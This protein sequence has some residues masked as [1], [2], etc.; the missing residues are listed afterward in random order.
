[1]R[2]ITNAHSRITRFVA[3]VTLY[4]ALCTFFAVSKYR[5]PPS[6]V[7]CIP[8]VTTFSMVTNNSLGWWCREVASKDVR[9][10]TCAGQEGKRQREL[11]GVGKGTTA[12]KRSYSMNVQGGYV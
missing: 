10:V 5:R 2:C 7:K 6:E 11:E 3:L 1:M 8:T 12:S 9:G 4:T